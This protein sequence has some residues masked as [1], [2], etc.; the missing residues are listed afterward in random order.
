MGVMTTIPITNC[1]DKKA[2]VALA[3]GYFTVNVSLMAAIFLHH[4]NQSLLQ[5]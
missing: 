1:G 2:S 5:L 4:F 3:L